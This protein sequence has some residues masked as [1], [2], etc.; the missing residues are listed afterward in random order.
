MANGT[1]DIGEERSG[2]REID[3]LFVHFRE[4]ARQLDHL[5]HKVYE[6]RIEEQNL[7]AESREAQL[8]ALQ[9]PDQSAFSIQ[10][11]GFHQLDGIDGRGG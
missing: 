6:T 2:I 7:I 10:H 8:Q 3:G 5:I 4:M 11:A 1:F 9:M